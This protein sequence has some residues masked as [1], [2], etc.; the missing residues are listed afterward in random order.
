M[1]AF[2]EYSS[3]LTFHILRETVKK[4]Q[5]KKKKKNKPWKQLYHGQI[6]PI[7]HH[8]ETCSKKKKN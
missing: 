7:S 4:V 6:S 1:L 2:H 8:R 5:V 3:N